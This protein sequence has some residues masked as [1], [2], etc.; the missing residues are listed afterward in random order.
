[1]YMDRNLIVSGSVTGPAGST[2][3]TGQT[4]TGS[5][6]V[7]STNTIDLQENSD[8]GEGDDFLRARAIVA[9]AFTG[10]TA[11]TIEAIQ[12]DDAAL[13]T[14]V[15]PIGSSGAI[16]VASLTAGALFE[17][18][19]N[20]RIGSKGQRY[21]GLRFT[22]TGTGTAGAILGDFGIDIQ[23]GRKFYPSGFTVA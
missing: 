5:S 21:L 6:A 1:M 23:D 22:P 4:V 20:S 14:N 11:L 16:P 8:I 18:Q 9:T 13:S 12:A 17:I 3:I 2:T 10:L 19:L 7:V 15:T